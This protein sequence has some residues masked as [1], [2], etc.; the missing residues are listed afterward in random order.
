MG[1]WV[2]PRALEAGP[3]TLQ[4]LHRAAQA[5]RLP[6]APHDG[7]RTVRRADGDPDPDPGHAPRRRAR[8]RRPL[9]IQGRPRSPPNATTPNSTGS[10]SC[11]EW[12]KEISDPHEFLDAVKLNLFPDE[13][14]VFTPKGEV[15][16]LPA[17]STPIDFAY[18]IHSEVG[19][20]CSGAKV[21]GTPRAAA[22]EAEGRRHRRDPRGHVRPWR[23]RRSGCAAFW[24]PIGA[25]ITGKGELRALDRG[26][27]IDLA[28]VD[29]DVRIEAP[30]AEGGDV[31]RHRLLVIG[32]RGDPAE[33]WRRQDQLRDLLEIARIDL[34][35]R[36]SLIE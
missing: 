5:E 14:F 10:G 19:S 1:P 32:A 11:V 30:A 16:N 36:Y 28:D 26:R 12:Q 31:V 2:D 18:A 27:E 8:H 35:T 4:G 23:A 17:G 24:T 25:T 20:H 34:P 9:E 3:G 29:E 22:P 13:V 6:V 33:D 15:I 21:N 7:D